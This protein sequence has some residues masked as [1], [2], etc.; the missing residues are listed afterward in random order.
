MLG[1]RKVDQGVHIV[2]CQAVRIP[3]MAGHGRGRLGMNVKAS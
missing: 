2:G 3:E 1:S